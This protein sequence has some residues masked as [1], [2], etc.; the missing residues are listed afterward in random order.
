MD[1]TKLKSKLAEPAQ[2][3]TQQQTS[4]HNIGFIEEP[5]SYLEEDIPQL[6][7]DI[8]D[9]CKKVV[10]TD[11]GRKIPL[12]EVKDMKDI[13]SIVT[14]IESSFNKRDEPTQTINVLVQNIMQT[15]EDDC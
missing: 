3:L 6:K 7:L 12:L 15:V 5:P 1:L 2:I 11:K 8:V 14:Q 9:W 13:A 10:D 4:N